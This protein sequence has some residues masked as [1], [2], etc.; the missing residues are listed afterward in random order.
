MFTKK[1]GMKYKG[2]GWNSLPTM[3]QTN[4]QAHTNHHHIT[5]NIHTLINHHEY[6]FEHWFIQP[7]TFGLVLRRST[8]WAIQS[9]HYPTLLGVILT[10]EYISEGGLL[11]ISNWI[12]IEFTSESNLISYMFTNVDRNSY[13][14]SFRI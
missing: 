7:T 11:K 3:A 2:R 14:I 10:F 5:V 4:T 13:L 8:N 12:L 9:W 1:G 6:I